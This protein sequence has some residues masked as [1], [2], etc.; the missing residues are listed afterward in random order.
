MYTLCTG[1]V[2]LLSSAAFFFSQ[3]S[4]PNAPIS[5]FSFSLIGPELHIP[6]SSSSILII[7]FLSSLCARPIRRTSALSPV[8]REDPDPC[9]VSWSL[10]QFL[11]AVVCPI[12]TSAFQ[13]ATKK[14]LVHQLDRTRNPPPKMNNA[15]RNTAQHTDSLTRAR[16]KQEGH[17]HIDTGHIVVW[18]VLCPFFPLFTSWSSLS[19]CTSL[20][21]NS[22]KTSQTNKSLTHLPPLLLTDTDGYLSRFHTLKLAQKNLPP[23]TCTS[24]PK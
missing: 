23:C 18:I 13:R 24:Q 4:P 16:E 20:A 21:L 6:P 15:Q 11:F 12:V 10:R 17:S 8:A 14:K 5:Y 2:W 22:K 1:Y 3:A 9:C 7:P 19:R